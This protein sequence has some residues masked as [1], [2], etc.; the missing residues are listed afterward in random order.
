MVKGIWSSPFS[1]FHLWFVGHIWIIF[2]KF[3]MEKGFSE[4]YLIVFTAFINRQKPFQLQ[5]SDNC[6]WKGF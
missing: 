5:K 6:D 2:S 4:A 1:M 3:C